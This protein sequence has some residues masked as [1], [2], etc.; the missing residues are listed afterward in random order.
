LPNTLVRI[1]A[2]IGLIL[3]TLG[4]AS[5]DTLSGPVACESSSECGF[6]LRI[7]GQLLGEGLFSVDEKGSISIG[8]PI[9]ITSDDG[10]SSMSIDSIG[11]NVDPSLLFAGGVVNNFGFDRT[12]SFTFSMPLIPALE[13]P[14]VTASEMTLSVTPQPGLFAQAYAISSAGNIMEAQDIDVPDGGGARTRINKGVDLFSESLIYS[15]L[16][17][18]NPG[19]IDTETYVQS[20]SG[21]I[22]TGGPYDFMTI[23]VSFGLTGNS[24]ASFAGRVDQFEEGG[25][26]EV[27]EP[28]AYMLVLAGMV[29]VGAIA[30]RRLS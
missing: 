13:V 5:A 27:P 8:E 30:R 2:A 18:F 21:L 20:A 15:A 19:T 7:D 28:S 4:F 10:L 9:R 16:G 22:T 6:E 11:G 14:I 29:L 26:S 23:T 25:P 12:F 3:G 17:D 24:A 1:S